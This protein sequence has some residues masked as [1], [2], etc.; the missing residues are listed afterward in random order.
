L[1]TAE[2]LADGIRVE[3]SSGDQ[4]TA[5]ENRLLTGGTGLPIPRLWREIDELVVMHLREQQEDS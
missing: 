2:I 5:D 3:F 4:E 1:T